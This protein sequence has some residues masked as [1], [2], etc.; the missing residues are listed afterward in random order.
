MNQSRGPTHALPLD[1]ADVL[2]RC[3]TTGQNV[4]VWYADGVPDDSA[5]ISLRCPACARVAPALTL[6]QKKPR[7]EAGLQLRMKISV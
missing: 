7:V 3:I 6:G 2:Y 5:Y 1:M 4:Q